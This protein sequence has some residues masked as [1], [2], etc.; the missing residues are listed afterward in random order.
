VAID[1]SKKNEDAISANTAALI[2][3]T[4][5]AQNRKFAGFEQCRKRLKYL[6]KLHF[7]NIVPHRLVIYV[8]KKV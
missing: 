6:S 7:S 2:V 8:L 1:R 5:P 4:V 3:S